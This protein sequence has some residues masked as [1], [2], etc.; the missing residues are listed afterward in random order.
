MAAA[1][2]PTNAMSSTGR[3][4]AGEIMGAYTGAQKMSR[5]DEAQQSS[6]TDACA[7]P[8]TNDTHQVL[9]TIKFILQQP[10]WI[11]SRELY[12]MLFMNDPNQIADLF[13][14]RWRL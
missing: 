2:A 3:R 10:G 8:N 6:I 9:G 13:G 7:A 4:S 12:R 1:G 14:S 5:V 11:V